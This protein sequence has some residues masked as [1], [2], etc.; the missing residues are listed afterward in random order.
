MFLSA[1]IAVLEQ[2]PVL[3]G[4]VNLSCQQI[5]ALIKQLFVLIGMDEASTVHAFLTERGG[6]NLI[7]LSKSCPVVFSETLRRLVE[8]EQKQG[9]PSSPSG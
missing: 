7:D 4:H 8:M 6:S 9:A 5:P 2:H 1:E 3:A